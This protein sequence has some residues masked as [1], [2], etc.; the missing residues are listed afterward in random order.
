[1]RDNIRIEKWKQ[2]EKIPTEFDLCDIYH[3]SRITIRKAIEELVRE[4]LLVKKKPIGTFVSTQKLI[5][6]NQNYTIVKSFTNEMKELGIKVETLKVNVI[7]SHADPTIATFL[8]VSPGSKIIILERV[9]GSKGKAIG[10]FKTYFKF[11]EIFSLNANTYNYSFYDYL[12]SLGIQITSNKEVVEAMLPTKNISNILHIN[13][14]TP[15]L[16]RCRF[17]SDAKK[18]FFEYTECY[19]IGNEYKYFVDFDIPIVP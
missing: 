8:K 19:Y 3:V 1:M 10:F 17:T 9:R 15:I 5:D 4:N 18:N 11:D 16:R 13:S 6:D 2:G 14:V 7:V 12:D